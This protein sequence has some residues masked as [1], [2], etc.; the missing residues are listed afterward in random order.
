[1]QPVALRYLAEQCKE[2]GLKTGLHTNGVFPEVIMDLIN[3]RL[4]D[5]IALDVKAEWNLYTVRGRERAV[6]DQVRESLK[7]CTAAF[8]TGILPE[9]EVVVT[10]FPGY[11]EEIMTISDDVATDV[12]LVLQQGNFT[13]IRPLKIHE[14]EK[15]ADRLCRPVRI[16]TRDEGEILYRKSE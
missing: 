13:G 16:R 9:F 15:I 7:I 8:H 11:G 10:L 3:N 4:I 6:G 5:H 14:L 1:M 2:I 12:E